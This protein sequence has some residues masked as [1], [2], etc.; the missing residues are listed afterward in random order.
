MTTHT[1][2]YEQN[3]RRA[4]VQTSLHKMLSRKPNIALAFLFGSFAK[5]TANA[6][7]DIDVAVLFDTLPDAY[8]INALRDR[9]ASRLKADVDIVVL[10]SASPI[11]KMQVLKHGVVICKKTDAAYSNFYTETFNQY[12]DLKMIRKSAEENILKGR[13]YA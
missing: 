7:S 8:Q 3:V 1:T 4:Q 5:G 6:T 11:I 9:L 10:N 2:H 12:T 13:I